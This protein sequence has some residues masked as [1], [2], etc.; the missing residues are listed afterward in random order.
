MAYFDPDNKEILKVIQS[1]TIEKPYTCQKLVYSAIPKS[2]KLKG[3]GTGNLQNCLVR[4]YRKEFIATAAFDPA[5][6]EGTY[7]GSKIFHLTEKGRRELLPWFKKPRIWSFIFAAITA[8]AT[9]GTFALL[10]LGKG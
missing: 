8:L 9:F 4:I 2:W 1:I 5:F 3:C 10:F 7:V 6:F